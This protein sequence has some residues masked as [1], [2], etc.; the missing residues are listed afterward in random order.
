MKKLLQILL[1]ISV[2]ILTLSSCDIFKISFGEG[3]GENGGD[4]TDNENT[5]QGGTEE[6]NSCKHNFVIDEAK[7]P[8]CTEEGLTEGKHC[9]L[10]G[11]VEVSQE[12][13]PMAHT[14]D[15]PQTISNSTCF[16]KGSQK[17]ACSACEYEEIIEI[18]KLTHDF[19]YDEET[20]FCS[21]SLCGAY[22]FEESIYMIVD[23]DTNWIEA[24][25][26]CENLGGHLVTISNQEEDVFVSSLIKDVGVFPVYWIGGVKENGS[27]VWVTGEEFGYT[28][29]AAGEPNNEG[30]YENYLQHWGEWNDCIL[31][32]SSNTL[33]GI[34]CE[35]PV[36]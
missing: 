8:T 10:C 15:D 27:W 32:S 29:W 19:I 23:I 33:T 31:E 20:G 28:N 4:V 11:V 14:F 2:L 30:G 5:E 1:I 35:W 34:I 24:K 21:C 22:K 13:I 36:E 17:I 12:K 25:E 26:Y 9:T 6:D 16:V 18:D 7:A 3:N